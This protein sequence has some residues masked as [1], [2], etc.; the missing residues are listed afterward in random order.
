MKKYT[1]R[2]G[3]NVVEI[4][5]T[6]DTPKGKVIINRLVK[7]NRKYGL[8]NAKESI[9]REARETFGVKQ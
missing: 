6:F 3:H 7:K 8:K 1:I 4:E 9:V 5:R 2:N